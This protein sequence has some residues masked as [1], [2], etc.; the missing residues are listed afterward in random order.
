MIACKCTGNPVKCACII[1]QSDD[2]DGDEA[3]SNN[4]LA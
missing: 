2:Y 4:D 3:E 1:E